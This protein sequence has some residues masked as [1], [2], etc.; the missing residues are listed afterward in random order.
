MIFVFTQL[1]IEL[2]AQISLSR[3]TLPSLSQC[4]A[5]RSKHQSSLPSPHPLLAVYAMQ[6]DM[7]YLIL[8]K[9][10]NGLSTIQPSDWLSY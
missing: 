10:T 2:E 6:A 1:L 4:T 9:P 7:G 5:S 3:R 8:D